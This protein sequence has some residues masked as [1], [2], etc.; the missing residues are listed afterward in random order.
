MMTYM[1]INQLIKTYAEL[2]VSRGN[3]PV[4]NHE[5]PNEGHL[6]WMCEQVP[7]FLLCGRRDKA[8]RWLGFIQGSL[9]ALGIRDVETMKFDNKPPE[10]EFDPGRI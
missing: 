7:Q 10:G 2:L 3:E 8:M 6:L 5:A 1:Q 9:W 4:R